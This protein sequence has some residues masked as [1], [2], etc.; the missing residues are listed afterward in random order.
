MNVLSRRVKM[1]SRKTMLTS[2]PSTSATKSRTAFVP[3]STAA[4]FTAAALNARRWTVHVPDLLGNPRADG[5]AL[6]HQMVRVVGVQALHAI[7]RAAA[8]AAGT[9][10]GVE[11]VAPLAGSRRRRRRRPGRTPRPSGSSP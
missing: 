11:S 10:E 2:A 8:D 1:R 7:G 4:N 3:T 5:I 9:I 6:A